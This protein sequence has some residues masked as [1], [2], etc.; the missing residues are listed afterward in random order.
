MSRQGDEGLDGPDRT[1]NLGGDQAGEV[2]EERHEVSGTRSPGSK[3]LDLLMAFIF[4]K[5]PRLRM[6]KAPM[7]TT[8]RQSR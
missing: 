5:T 6:I 8:R 7:A 1:K 3:P 2:K 4:Y